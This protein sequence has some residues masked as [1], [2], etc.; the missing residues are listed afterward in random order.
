M[1]AADGEGLENGEK[2]ENTMARV[3]G[4]GTNNNTGGG[5]GQK[6]GRG[7]RGGRGRSG[8]SAPLTEQ[9][10]MVP[11]PSRVQV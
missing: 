4:G 6:K 10:P 9:N 1:K 8:A 3:G 2:R 7:K 11:P 5:V